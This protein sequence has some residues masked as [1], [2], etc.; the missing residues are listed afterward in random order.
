MTG[1]KSE[2]EYNRKAKLQAIESY[3]QNLKRRSS[4]LVK[5]DDSEYKEEAQLLCC[6]Y[7][8]S[9]GS[10]FYASDTGSRKNFVRVLKQYGREEVL[11]QIHPKQLQIWLSEPRQKRLGR[12]RTALNAVLENAE[13]KLYTEDEILALGKPRLSVQDFDYLKANLWRGTIAAIAYQRIR[14]RLVHEMG[15]PD[16]VTFEGTSFKGE[17]V[18]ALDFSLLHRALCR[19]IEAMLAISL[20]EEKFYGHDLKA[21]AEGGAAEGENG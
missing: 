3:F 14:N 12:I 11:W 7:I 17:Q 9:L 13:K 2:T 1:N 18:P 4:L 8:E 5:L 19:I 10:A 16:A 15:G 6:C 20:K 21:S